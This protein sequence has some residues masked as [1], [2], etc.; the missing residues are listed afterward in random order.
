MGLSYGVLGG[1]D[2][3]EDARA[4][5]ESLALVL[6]NVDLVGS[7]DKREYF[8]KGERGTVLIKTEQFDS[9]NRL[10]V[11]DFYLYTYILLY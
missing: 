6:I 10:L 4:E 9:T 11:I 2:P 3:I 7:I 8:V 5:Q 1:M